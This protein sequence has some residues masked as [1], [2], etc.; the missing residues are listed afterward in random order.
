MLCLIRVGMD[1]KRAKY[2]LLILDFCPSR[3][4][5]RLKKK[6]SQKDGHKRKRKRKRKKNISNTDIPY[7]HIVPCI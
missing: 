4:K 1:M 6:M 7:N 2:G 5:G 3:K